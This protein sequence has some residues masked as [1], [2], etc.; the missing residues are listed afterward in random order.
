MCDEQARRDA[1]DAT[2]ESVQ[3]DRAA[4]LG[5]RNGAGRPVNQARSLD[6]LPPP[7]TMAELADWEA[8]QQ[9]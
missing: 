1:L 2:G 5:R 7:P 8:E 3:R 4:K 9:R 6:E